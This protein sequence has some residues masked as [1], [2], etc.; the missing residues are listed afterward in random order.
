MTDTVHIPFSGNRQ[1]Q[2]ILLIG[3]ALEKGYHRR[4]VRTD[5]FGFIVPVDVADEAGNAP[6][7]SRSARGKKAAPKVD[8]DA[9]DTSE[10]E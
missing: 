10:K 8:F 9:A 5:S 6:K 4:V 3:T 7:K 1:D 2:A